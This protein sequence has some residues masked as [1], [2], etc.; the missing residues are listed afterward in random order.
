MRVLLSLLLTCFL[1][2]HLFSQV[3]TSIPSPTV[4]QIYNFSAGD[5]FEYHDI[6]GNYWM[7]IITTKENANNTSVTYTYTYNACLNCYYSNR[8]TT[9]FNQSETFDDLDSVY[10]LPWFYQYARSPIGAA[11]TDTSVSIQDNDTVWSATASTQVPYQEDPG[12]SW[13]T[14]WEYEEASFGIGLGLM[15][16]GS[17]GIYQG[18]DFELIYAHKANGQIWGTP[19]YFPTSINVPG[20]RPLNLS[21]YPNPT[22]SVLQ[23]ETES[24]EDYELHLCDITG[25]QLLSHKFNIRTE[26]NLSQFL[27]GMYLIE[28]FDHDKLLAAT[29][30]VV[31]Q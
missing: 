5:T 30:K 11:I 23:I 22:N 18:Y 21:V 8:D 14:G 9:L 12:D 19:Y 17:W 10:Y 20:E 13:D 6:S 7:D 3:L 29:R 28:I 16:S 2:V 24:K 31:L 27:H 1:Y 15:S 26:L 25:H 4:R